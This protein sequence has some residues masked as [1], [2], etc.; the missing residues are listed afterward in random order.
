MLLTFNPH[1]IIPVLG[2]S[3]ITNGTCCSRSKKKPKPFFILASLPRIPTGSKVFCYIA[4]LGSNFWI[5]FIKLSLVG[6]PDCPDRTGG[7]E[8]GF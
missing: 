2:Q 3:C 1:K 5:A 4:T 8:S 6:Y 7:T